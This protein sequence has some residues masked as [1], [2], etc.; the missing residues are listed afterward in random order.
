V[1]SDPD[2]LCIAFRVS[3]LPLRVK[4]LKF[5]LLWAALL[6]S[7]KRT[8]WD[9]RCLR[10]RTVLSHIAW[11]CNRILKYLST[12][13]TWSWALLKS[14]PVVKFLKDFPAFYETRRFITAFTRA[15]Q[16]SLYWSRPIQSTPSL[17]ILRNSVLILSAHLSFGPQNGISPPG[18]HT[19]NI[20]AFHFDLIRA[21]CPANHPP[22]LNHSNH[23][24]R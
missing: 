6:F 13:T 2:R 3:K 12:L 1:N 18:S 5:P 15:L 24:W 22:W 17:P 9:R 10:R 7:K 4:P 11:I 19:N 14:P 16:L 23:D 20:H 21:T 8:F